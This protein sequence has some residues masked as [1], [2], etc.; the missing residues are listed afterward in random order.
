MGHK[1][2]ACKKPVANRIKG[3]GMNV[4]EEYYS[5]EKQGTF[6]GP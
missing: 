1:M 5:E 6:H 4:H 2:T 3:I